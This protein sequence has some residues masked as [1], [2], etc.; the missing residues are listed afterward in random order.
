MKMMKNKF[1]L[2]IEMNINNNKNKNMIHRTRSVNGFHRRIRKNDSVLSM[3]AQD[4]VKLSQYW[5]NK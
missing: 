4:I 5:M 2:D 1:E 3:N